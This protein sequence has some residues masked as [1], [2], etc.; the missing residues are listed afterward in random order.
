[1]KYQSDKDRYR[2]A[3]V[4][5]GSSPTQKEWLRM[6]MLRI[7]YPGT[8]MPAMKNSVLKFLAERKH[9]RNLQN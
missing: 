7:K 2:L 9:Q 8:F 1:M 5:S 4:K 6:K 3:G